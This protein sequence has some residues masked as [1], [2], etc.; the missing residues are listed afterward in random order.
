MIDAIVAR[1][2]TSA[3]IPNAV[4][5]GPWE[6]PPSP[7]YVCVKPEIHP[8]GRGIRIIAH[9]TAEESS[10]LDDYIFNEVS[11]ILKDYEFTDTNGNNLVVKDAEEYTEVMADNDDNTIS[12]E[13]LFYVPSRLH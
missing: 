13:R 4:K 6:A 7:P 8:A 10:I 2:Q 9:T 3:T 1:L 11:E 5:F 12:M